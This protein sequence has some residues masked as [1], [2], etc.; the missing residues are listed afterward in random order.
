MFDV[1]TIAGDLLWAIALTIMVTA[2]QLAGRRVPRGERVR[3]FGA[4]VNRAFGLWIVPAAAF[5]FSLWLAWTV[6]TRPGAGDMALIQFAVRATTASLAALL[7]LR[8]LK[9]ILKP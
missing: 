7:H 3:M 9:G 6:R 5:A 4:P 2:S 1:L 8:L